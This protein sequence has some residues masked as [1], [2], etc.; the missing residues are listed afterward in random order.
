M[1]CGHT[2]FNVVDLTCDGDPHGIGVLSVENVRSGREAGWGQAYIKIIA[3][4][5]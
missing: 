2:L 1:F 4:R 3:Q 5:P